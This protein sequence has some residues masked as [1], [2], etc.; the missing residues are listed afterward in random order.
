MFTFYYLIF[1][2]ISFNWHNGKLVNLGLNVVMQLENVCKSMSFQRYLCGSDHKYH[3]I[4]TT[5]LGSREHENN[6][7]EVSQKHEIRLLKV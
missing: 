3:Y 1:S 6:V 2:Y 4:F 5:Y 7:L